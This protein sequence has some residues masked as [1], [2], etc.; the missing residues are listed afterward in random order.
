MQGIY[1]DTDGS[2]I[3]NQTLP[4][5]LLQA[6]AGVASSTGV[7][8]T[9]HSGV[10]NVMFDPAQCI[11]YNSSFSAA[12]A[13]AVVVDA[14]N[15]TASPRPGTL[16]PADSVWCSP[17]VTFRRLQYSSSDPTSAALGGANINLVDLAANRSTVVPYIAAEDG[18]I[19]T[20]A[21]GR[22]WLLYHDTPARVEVNQFR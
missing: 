16:T 20:V 17:N 6:A 3:S 13:A 11:Y 21:A 10:G 1:L 14:T 22:G 12:A 2:L 18:Y 19:F 15:T 8:A 4:A 7:N 5:A 9:L